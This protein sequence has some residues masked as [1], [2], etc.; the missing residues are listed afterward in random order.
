[1]K[2]Y[3]LTNMKKKSLLLAALMLAAPSLMSAQNITVP[4]PEFV[5]SYYI[6]TSDSTYSYLP[7]ES[8][9]V[10][11]HTSLLSKVGKIAGQAANVV[12]AAGGIGAYASG[13]LTGIMDGVKVMGSAANAGM[14]ADAISSMAF[15]EGKDI[16]FQGPHSPY[17][18]AKTGG[19]IVIIA[20][21]GNNSA[22]PRD[23]YRIVRLNGKKKTR[24]IRWQTITPSLFGSDDAEKIGY[25]NFTGHRYGNNSYII[26]IPANENQSG[27]YGIFYMSLASATDVPVATFSIE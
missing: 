7:K 8:G 1:M 2:K 17:K 9:A 25:V 26:T 21:N 22:D 27:E 16:V 18:T 24:V 6:L 12:S 15:A 3:I 5:N 13:S 14:A 19:S 20:N 23:L 11:K 4:E 10:V